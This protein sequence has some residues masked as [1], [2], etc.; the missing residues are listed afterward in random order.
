MDGTLDMMMMISRQLVMSRCIDS[1]RFVRFEKSQQQSIPSDETDSTSPYRIDVRTWF[2]FS[3][4]AFLTKQFD[5]II[6]A[7]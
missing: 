5:K 1:I 7:V 4:T 2:W 3:V 6:M